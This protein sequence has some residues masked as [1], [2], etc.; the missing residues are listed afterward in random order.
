MMIKVL[1]YERSTKWWLLDN[2]AKMSLSEDRYLFNPTAK[3]GESL[4]REGKSFQS[5]IEANDVVLL[6]KYQTLKEEDLA[7]TSDTIDGSFPVRCCILHCTLKNGE[8]Q[9][10]LFDSM[11]YILNDD[12]KTIDKIIANYCEV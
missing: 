11:A 1:V 7:Y 2:V 6:S 12:G 9:S 3:A 5:L 4:K 10:I 8:E